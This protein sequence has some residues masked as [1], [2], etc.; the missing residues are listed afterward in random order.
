MTV[1][2]SPYAPELLPPV[3]VRYL[4][5]HSH[6]ENRDAVVELFAAD[7]RVVDEGIEHSGADAIRGWLARTGSAY[8]YTTTFLGQRST[9][10]GRWVILARLEGT[11]PGGVAE[12]R[13]QVAT[14]GDRIVDLV[15]AP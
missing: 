6:P 5:E 11:F 3:V 10:D 2:Y 1:E 13:Y 7:A 9:G 4:E 15:I 14:Q 8:T 12:L